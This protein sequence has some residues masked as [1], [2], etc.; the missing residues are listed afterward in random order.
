MK[1]FKTYFY[2]FCWFVRFT[3]F[4]LILTVV[5]VLRS[6]ET[7]NL[8]YCKMFVLRRVILSSVVL[9]RKALK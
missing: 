4:A 2:A 7:V 9:A 1:T 6:L 5:Q 8:G 3:W